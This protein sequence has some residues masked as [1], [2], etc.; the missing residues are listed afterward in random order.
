MNIAVLADIHSNHVALDRDKRLE[1][2]PGEILEYGIGR[3]ECAKA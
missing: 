3:T 1:K 2:H